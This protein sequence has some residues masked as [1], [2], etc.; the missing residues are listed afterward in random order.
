MPERANRV[1]SVQE[2]SVFPIPLDSDSMGF[3]FLWLR[4]KAGFRDCFRAVWPS[5][6]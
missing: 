6:F 4:L 5:R 3:G 2:P 1:L